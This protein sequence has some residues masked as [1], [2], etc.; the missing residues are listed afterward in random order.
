MVTDITFVHIP[1]CDGHIFGASVHHLAPIFLDQTGIGLPWVA[2]HSNNEC[3][4]LLQ[5]SLVTLNAPNHLCHLESV[6]VA[7]VL[8]AAWRTTPSLCRLAVETDGASEQG[9]DCQPW[10]RGLNMRLEC[11]SRACLTWVQYQKLKWINS[12]SIHPQ[13]VPQPIWKTAEFSF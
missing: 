10:R 1:E 6:P 7:S 5:V 8:A 9:K 2:S 11:G 3:A 4:G 12:M 13:G